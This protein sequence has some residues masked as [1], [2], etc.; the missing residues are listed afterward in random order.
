[1]LNSDPGVLESCRHFTRCHGPT[2]PMNKNENHLVPLAGTA[3][4]S[5]YLRHGKTDNEIHVHVLTQSGME[6]GNH[7][8][9]SYLGPVSK[10]CG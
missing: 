8:L 4:R 6:K 5:R 7:P 1:M 9:T 10:F 2:F 3:Q